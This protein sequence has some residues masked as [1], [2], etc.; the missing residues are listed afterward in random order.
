[1]RHD[2]REGREA[3]DKDQT[4]PIILKLSRMST[5]TDSEL[6]GTVTSTYNS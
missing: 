2:E 6:S 4:T 5:S 1:M 3:R